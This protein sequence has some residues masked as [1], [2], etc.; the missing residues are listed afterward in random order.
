MATAVRSWK[1]G[2][3][4]AALQGELR[5]DPELLI[6]RP[7]PAGTDD[8]KGIT[9]A[10][11]KRYLDK[12]LGCPIG[13]VIVGPEVGPQ[14]VATVTVTDPRGAFGRV[15]G[16]MARPLPLAPG[17]HPSASVSP[18]ASV[19]A[20]ASVGAFTVVEAGATV[21][22]GAKVYAQCYVGEGCTVGENTILFPRVTLYQDIAVGARCILHSGVVIGADGFGFVWDGKRRI[23]V[24]QIGG[25]VIED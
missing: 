15:L 10:G 23:K 22:P 17:I 8:P 18:Q 16:L 21:G 12:A 19:D 14:S 9:F 11:D 6:E 2:E 5:G 13:A 4:A 20:S 25:V 7:V 24:P 1:L 3:I